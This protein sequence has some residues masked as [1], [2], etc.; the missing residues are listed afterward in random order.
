MRSKRMVST[1]FIPIALSACTTTGPTHF[2]TLVPV[3]PA[4]AYSCAIREV[5]TLGYTVANTNR[6]SG[7]IVAERQASGLGTALLTGKKYFDQMTV[8]AFENDGQTT[9]RVT[10]GR[11]QESAALF[12]NMS[13]SN[14]NKP[15]DEAMGHARTLLEACAPGGTIQVQTSGE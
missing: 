15:S 12:G 11:A 6:E 1:L 3:A 5:T 14:A 10:V 7:L 2:T 8:L 9:V 13:R 4:D